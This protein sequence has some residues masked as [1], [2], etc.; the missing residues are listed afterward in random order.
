M[1]DPGRAHNSSP[2]RY[3]VAGYPSKYATSMKPAPLRDLNSTI[4]HTVLG[5]SRTG[6]AFHRFKSTVSDETEVKKRTDSSFVSTSESGSSVHKPLPF[7]TRRAQVHARSRSEVVM[8]ARRLRIPDI[9]YDLDGDGVVGPTDFFIARQFDGNHDYK[10]DPEERKR[11]L[12]RVSEGA[13]DHVLPNPKSVRLASKQQTEELMEKTMQSDD[14]PGSAHSGSRVKLLD[15]RRVAQMKEN[16]DLERSYSARMDRLREQIANGTISLTSRPTTSSSDTGSLRRTRSD[17]I[18][19]RRASA[20]VLSGMQAENSEI[21]LE[22]PHSPQ[23]SYVPDPEKTSRLEMLALQKE[24]HREEV[25]R[26]VFGEK[27]HLLLT[28]SVKIADPPVVPSPPARPRSAAMVPPLLLSREFQAAFTD[29][30]KENNFTSSGASSER[31]RATGPGPA[32][33]NDR[34]PRTDRPSVA[35][36]RRKKYFEDVALKVTAVQPED[37]RPVSAPTHGRSSRFSKSIAKGEQPPAEPQVS[38]EFN[39]PM[40]SSFSKDGVF[41][42]RPLS[43]RSCVSPSSNGAGSRPGSSATASI[44]NSSRPPTANSIGRTGSFNERTFDSTPTSFDV[45]SFVPAPPSVVGDALSQVGL[46]RPPSS[47]RVRSSQAIHYINSEGGPTEIAVR[48]PDP[49]SRTVQEHLSKSNSL[50][51]MHTPASV[52]SH[53]HSSF[54][55]GSLHSSSVMIPVREPEKAPGSFVSAS[56]SSTSMLNPTPPPLSAR[57]GSPSRGKPFVRTGGFNRSSANV[58]IA[59]G[60]AVPC[61]PQPVLS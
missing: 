45:G 6:E 50:L 43:A 4:P 17:M 16:D 32:P 20:R 21:N 52:S 42:P 24:K 22:R 28:K 25:V 47:P 34:P 27:A 13:F 29:G 9:S 2:P 55:A 26:T 39:Q 23:G 37:R 36:S 53:L 58:P 48:Q 44:A 30:E 54:S 5:L 38:G 3:S 49:L 59:T 18:D 1:S 10:L 19:A 14:R 11:A 15:L 57:S 7:L 35:D 60:I 33:F 56:S 40:F 41:S 61:P 12:V 8:D 51:A 46:A 31:S